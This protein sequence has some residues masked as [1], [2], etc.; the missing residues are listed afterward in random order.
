MRRFIVLVLGASA[1]VLML[2]LLTGCGKGA[3][4]V[5]NGRKITEDEFHQRLETVAGGETLRDMIARDI[6]TR[7]AEQRGIRVTPRQVDDEISKLEKQFPSPTEFVNF[8]RSRGQTPEQFRDERAFA[9]MLD[10]LRTQDVQVTDDDVREHFASNRDR[11]DRPAE[12][13]LSEIVVDGKQQ[14]AEILKELA[15]PD[16]SFAALARERSKARTSAAGG[17]LPAVSL[18]QLPEEWQAAIQGLTAGEVSEPFESGGDWRIAKVLAMTPAQAAS[19]EDPD[20]RERVYETIR[21]ERAKS[22]FDVL[23]DVLATGNH[24]VVVRWSK[25]KQLETEFLPPPDLPAPGGSPQ[26]PPSAPPAGAGAGPEPGPA[27]GDEPGPPAP[28]AGDEPEPNE[29]K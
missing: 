22:S 11:Y 2:A 12:Y 9:L 18:A 17:S 16:A 10:Q 25:Y 4:A 14:A 13:R 26:P 19:L 24:R 3:V 6:L 23:Q 7:E 29:D 5:V 20:T 27:G 28:P 21:L 1:A 15:K 8:L